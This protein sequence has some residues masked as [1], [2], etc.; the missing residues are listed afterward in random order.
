MTSTTS[1]DR[2]L[3]ITRL[4]AVLV[5]PFLVAAFLILFVFP[6]RTEQ[7]FAWKLQPQMSAMMLG[8][9]YLTGVFFFS[10]VLL[11]R[12]WR[13]VRAGF[14]PVTTFA[15]V[16]GI[17]T[18]LHWD[19]FNH[20]H[21]AFWIWAVLYFTTPFIV[22]LVWYINQ[23]AVGEGGDAAGPRLPIL[24]RGMIALVGVA[25]ILVAL[26]SLFQPDWLIAIWPWKLS[27]LTTRVA[28][29]QFALSGVF[30][31]IVLLDPAWNSLRVFLRSQLASPVFYLIAVVASQSDFNWA[32]PLAWLFAANVAVLFVLGIPGLYLLM[33]IRNREWRLRKE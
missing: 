28:G 27:A 25:G 15:A 24:I 5:I 22:P 17:A 1:E 11:S 13:Q 21:L 26:I 4:L 16:M 18:I 30:A 14:L 2:I 10:T 33:E 12:H 9:T 23:R 32:N 6:G 3:L 31:V 20:E 8:A 29:A 7:L 19:R